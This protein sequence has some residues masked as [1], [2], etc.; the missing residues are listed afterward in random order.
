LVLAAIIGEDKS[1]LEQ[2]AYDLATGLAALQFSRTY[3]YEADEYSIRYMTD[4]HY[5]H[6]K[7]LA[8]FF[9]Q[10]ADDGQTGETFEFLST[11]PSDANRLENMNTIWSGLGSPT[12]EYFESEYSDFKATMLN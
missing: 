9:E 7:G 10:L 1:D 2:I 8:G 5:Y 6:P 11:H 12:G 3:E 4:T